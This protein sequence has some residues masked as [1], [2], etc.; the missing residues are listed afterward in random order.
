MAFSLSRHGSA[1][2]LRFLA[3]L[4]AAVVF[5][6]IAAYLIT[7][8]SRVTE[9][10]NPAAIRPEIGS[11]YIVSLDI[12]SGWPYVVEEDSTLEPSRSHLI[13][14]EDK[15][16]LGPAHTLH[17]QIRSAGAGRYSHWGSTIIFATSDDSDPRTNGRRYS[18]AA[19]A[20]LDMSVQLLLAATIALIDIALAFVFRTTILH[21]LRVYQRIRLSPTHHACVPETSRVPTAFAGP[22]ILVACAGLAASG[23]LGQIVIAYPGMPKDAALAVSVALHAMLGC[24]TST[25]LWAASA[26]LCRLILRDRHAGVATILLP[27]FPLCLALIAGLSAIALLAPWGRALALAVW[28]AC[29]VPL[30]S[31]HPPRDQIAKLLKVAVVLAPLAM[32]F[33]VWLGLLWH[34]PTDT[35]S[36]SPSG[37]LSFYAGNIWSLAVSPY[38]HLNLGYENGEAITYFNHLY[39]ALGATLLPLPGFD[40]FLFLLTSCGSSYV[41]FTCVALHVYLSDRATRTIRLLDLAVIVLAVIAAARYPYWVAESIPL[42]FTPA[43]AISVWWMT[44]RGQRSIGWSIAAIL[45]AFG[46]TALSK[47]TSA[48]VFLPLAASHIWLHLFRS[49][50]WIKAVLFFT[51]AVFAAYAAAMLTRFLPVFLAAADLGPES[52]RFQTWYFVLRDASTAAMIPLTWFVATPPVALSLSIGLASFLFYSFI[53]QVNF[54]VAVLVIGLIVISLPKQRT[55]ARWIAIAAFAAASPGMLLGEPAGSLTGVVWIICLGG[56]VLVAVLGAIAREP[57]RLSS[58]RLACLAGS[59]ILATLALSLVGIAN[60]SIIADSGW[61]RFQHEPLTPQLKEIWTAVR[62]LTPRDALIFTDQVD[63]TTN[64]VGGWNTYAFSGQRQVFISSYYTAFELRSN[65]SRRDAVFAVNDAVL[66]GARSPKDVEIQHK[67]TS[68]YAVVSAKRSV[69]PRW[70]KIAGNA[71]YALY[72]IAP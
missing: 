51:G 15:R 7:Y 3:W 55:T 56:G 60:G 35:L 30:A 50:A 11:A 31:W 36:G 12:H 34:G 71:R 46:G 47:V 32:A 26:G 24:M 23:W 14:F 9:T 48:L 63:D 49:P 27:S 10:I 68:F 38:P 59:T 22:V 62:T 44:E 29:L 40:P 69:P 67:H 8:T 64:I 53:F 39:P 61:S 13:L 42:V 17:D 52:Y 43:L 16:A 5:H 45:A 72:R 25:G 21:Q 65:A 70:S 1:T 6:A 57:V 2:R 66:S 20:T 33:G 37:D 58:F 19:G 28:F 18:F 41:L 54:V 4:I